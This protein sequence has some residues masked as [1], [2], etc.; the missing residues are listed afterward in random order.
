MAKSKGYVAETRVWD[1]C[2]EQLPS[3]TRSSKEKTGDRHSLNYNIMFFIIICLSPSETGK[4][5]PRRHLRTRPSSSTAS[6]IRS[7]V[8]MPPLLP[9]LP[10]LSLPVFLGQSNQL[11]SPWSL[12]FSWSSQ[13]SLHWR[14]R[15][16]CVFCQSRLFLQSLPGVTPFG[17]PEHHPTL[18]GLSKLWTLCDAF[19]RMLPCLFC[20]NLFE[21]RSHGA[22]KGA[23]RFFQ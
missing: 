20:D 10:C 13:Q 9:S 17:K 2:H 1:V 16:L 19:P 8:L 3:T 15:I 22:V 14:T 7:H 4:V 23:Q 5:K 6:E 18:A 21:R 12:V 11:V